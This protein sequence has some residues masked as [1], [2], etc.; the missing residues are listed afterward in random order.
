MTHSQIKWDMRLQNVKKSKSI[1]F[2]HFFTI[3]IEERPSKIL[4]LHQHFFRNLMI[5]FH[6]K[7]RPIFGQ[8]QIFA[9]KIDVQMNLTG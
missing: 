1:F 4:N 2:G 6:V 3:L 8:N 9:I 7:K 5:F